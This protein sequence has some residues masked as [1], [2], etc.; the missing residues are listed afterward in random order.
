MR[1]VSPALVSSFPSREMQFWPMRPEGEWAG[2]FYE[3]HLTDEMTCKEET[4]PLAG[5]IMSHLEGT[6]ELPLPPRACESSQP[7]VQSLS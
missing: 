1:A 3:N 5:Q 2:E 6:Q 7:A 4:I